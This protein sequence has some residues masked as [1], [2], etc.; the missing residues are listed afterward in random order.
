MIV[1]LIYRYNNDY[2]KI[3]Y[4]DDRPVQYIH[5]YNYIYI[6]YMIKQ[7]ESFDHP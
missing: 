4:R 5:I 6:Q 3:F 2:S 7:H 1:Y